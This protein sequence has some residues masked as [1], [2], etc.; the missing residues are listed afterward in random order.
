MQDRHNIYG[1]YP[2]VSLSIQG[3]L[4]ACIYPSIAGVFNEV[5]IFE[6]PTRARIVMWANTEAKFVSDWPIIGTLLPG[7][8]M[9]QQK[10]HALLFFTFK[11]TV[12]EETYMS[13][14]RIRIIEIIKDRNFSFFINKIFCF[15]IVFV[16]NRIN[17]THIHTL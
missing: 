7:D 5:T 14:C 15:H 1:L 13:F 9:L 6:A 11:I 2:Y 12:I 10:K 8:L 4:V 3:D 16:I 17:L